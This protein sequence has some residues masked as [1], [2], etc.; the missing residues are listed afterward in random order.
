MA[1]LS[2][3]VRADGTSEL[4]KVRD[5]FHSVKRDLGKGITVGVG[6]KLAEL[7]QGA[8]AGIKDKIGEGLKTA[9][10]QEDFQVAFQQFTGSV[11]NAISLTE[12]L[13]ALSV[14]TPFTGGE[15]MGAAKSLLSA[16]VEWN[17]AFESIEQ[18]SNVADSGEVLQALA[19]ALGKGFAKGKFQTKELN[20]FIE[21]GVNLY[22]ALAKAMQVPEQELSKMIEK[23]VTFQQVMSGIS[24]LTGKGGQFEG[25]AERKSQSTSGLMS[26]IGGGIEEANKELFTPLLQSVQPMLKLLAD[27]MGKV[28]GVAKNLGGY[29]A[30]LAPIMAPFA[31][32]WGASKI[33]GAI[34]GAVKL[35]QSF[36]TATRGAAAATAEVGQ[37]A[38]AAQGKVGRLK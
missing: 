27:N 22:P 30:K 26:T 5:K 37:A 11:E 17:T 19:T 8:L 2:F 32:L 36:A 13:N 34:S 15:V 9:I 14:K 38:T 24:A 10:Q 16:G 3:K 4:E 20:Q 6:V 25:F 18:L 23:G 12:K 33:Q 28:V 29:L 21:R 35:V 1:D 31:A 7:G